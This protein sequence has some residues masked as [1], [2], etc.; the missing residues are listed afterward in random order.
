[1]ETPAVSG[2]AAIEQELE[3]LNN[4]LKQYRE[5]QEKAYESGKESLAT[6]LARKITQVMSRKKALEA[7]LQESIEQEKAFRVERAQKEK[8]DI[9]VQKFKQA[10]A[11]TDK[12]WF[13]EVCRCLNGLRASLELSPD[14]QSDSSKSSMF[15][16]II[17]TFSV[18]REERKRAPS[19]MEYVH[20]FKKNL[21]FW[22]DE[23]EK[24]TIKLDGI[25]DPDFEVTEN[26]KEDMKVMKTFR[27]KTVKRIQGY[28]SDLES[29][30]KLIGP[31]ELLHKDLAKYKSPAGGNAAASQPRPRQTQNYADR[32]N[33]AFAVV[34]SPKSP[35]SRQHNFQPSSAAYA[36]EGRFSRTQPLRSYQT[37]E[38]GGRGPSSD[39]H[40]RR[41][42]NSAR[43][44]EAEPARKW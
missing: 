41:P 11:A 23:F 25:I 16:S 44:C 26:F 19:T 29:T 12:L 22:T 13:D 20:H 38:R 6:T 37:P 3:K 5:A 8:R 32:R 18:A 15:S 17:S 33:A 21:K 36:Q 43:R 28:M 40:V 24:L 9:M 31:L 35:P 14:E 10:R 30:A 27:K 1:M 2:P 7:S 4:V 42:P 39:Q 34:E